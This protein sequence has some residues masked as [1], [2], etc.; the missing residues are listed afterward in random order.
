MHPRSSARSAVLFVAVAVFSSA[1][2]SATPSAATV[3]STRITD[4]Q[5]AAEAKF[6]TFFSG[7]Q[8][9]PCAPPDPGP[10]AETAAAACNRVTLS[11]LIRT[12]LIDQ[13]AAQHSITVVD[14]DVQQALSGFESQIGT[15]KVTQGLSA[16]GLTRDDLNTFAHES[17]LGSA[18]QD[19]VLKAKLGDAKLHQLY[20][21][22]IEQ[23]TL[24]DAEHILVKTE[25]EAN[26]IYAQVT[27]P[28]AT[29][30][31]FQTLAKKKSIDTQSGANG[32]DLGSAPASTYVPEFSAALVALR[33]GEISKP[34]HTQSGWHVI[35]LVSKG[36][37]PYDK[38][39]PQLLQNQD[40]AI[41]E[42]WLT[43]Q[44]AATTVTVNPRYGKLDPKTLSVDRITSTD[45]S[46]TPTPTGPTSS[47]TGPT[48][49]VPSVGA[50]TD[51]RTP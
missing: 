14:A 1:C 20:Q 19:D 35:R 50:P 5:V 23:F 43:E 28:G 13:Y 15:D 29:E 39:L 21:Q 32:G 2:R 9:Q 10:P 17:L 25:A 12:A 44:A 6:L 7:L 26:D 27:A 46:T 40:P 38:A 11:F 18:V 24:F 4:E 31:D 47:L 3:G 34:V 45:T 8:Q 42:T 22:G 33:P 30:K 37:T 49:G 41:F 16:D 51:S 48:G 36:V